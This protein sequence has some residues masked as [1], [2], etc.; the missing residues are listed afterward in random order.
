MEKS[1]NL[2]KDVRD[3]N[4][5]TYLVTPNK[6]KETVI[7]N[8][9]D[10]LTEDEL[11]SGSSPSLSLS[12][13]KNARESIKAKSRKKPSHHL[14]FSDA[15]SGTFRKERKEAGR[16]QNQPVQA[17]RNAPI[18]PEGATPPVLPVGMMPPMLLVHPAFG[19]RSTFYMP[20]T[21]LIC[22]P[23]DMLSLPLRQHILDYEPPCRFFIPS[24]SMFDGFSNPYDHML[25]YNH[26]MILNVGNDRLLCKVFSA[27]LRGPALTWFHKLPC[28]SINSFNE[29]CDSFVL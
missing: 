25:H 1:Y 4:Q 26:A 22:R 11:S 3:G 9:V 29:P 15:V 2:G 7:H 8:N 5:A 20:P 12:S 28:N 16:R 27:S 24:F 19:T 21:A 18:F 6:W 23:D 14:A 17:L 10:T 13:T